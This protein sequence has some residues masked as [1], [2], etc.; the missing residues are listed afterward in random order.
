MTSRTRKNLDNAPLARERARAIRDGDWQIMERMRDLGTLWFSPWNR[1]RL[2]EGLDELR[3]DLLTGMEIMNRWQQHE[4]WFDIGEW[5][6]ARAARPVRLTEAGLKALRER[7]LYDME[8]VLGGLVEPGWTATPAP[9]D[10]HGRAGLL[11]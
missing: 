4:D 2:P 5:D 6:R 11:T 7:H 10:G 8:P 9:G 1:D 3:V